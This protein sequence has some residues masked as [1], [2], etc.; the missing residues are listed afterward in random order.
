M[1]LQWAVK[2]EGKPHRFSIYKRIRTT[3]SSNNSKLCSISE[4]QV[5]KVLRIYFLRIAVVRHQI[6]IRIYLI[7]RQ[8]EQLL[9]SQEQLHL[10][11]KEINSINKTISK[12]LRFLITKVLKN[13][14]MR[15][16]E[17]ETCFQLL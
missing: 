10:D 4:L 3:I 9:F 11:S 15:V 12:M 1:L 16:M 14:K 2:L 8:L 17:T 13:Q 5:D 6:M 7:Q